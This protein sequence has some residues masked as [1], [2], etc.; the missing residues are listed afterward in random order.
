MEYCDKPDYQMLSNLLERCMKRRGVRESDPYDWEKTAVSIG[1]PQP[2]ISTVP[3]PTPTPL[4][5]RIVTSTDNVMITT[6]DN[7]QENIEPDNR[8]EIEV[9]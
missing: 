1:N 2:P 3:T 7:N 5:P 9:T 8:K 6:L 4:S